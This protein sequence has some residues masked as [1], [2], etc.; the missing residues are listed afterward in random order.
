MLTIQFRSI[1]GFIL[2]NEKPRIAKIVPFISTRSVSASGMALRGGSLGWTD[3][4]LII[5]DI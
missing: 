5:V 1:C 3:V 4:G 2:S